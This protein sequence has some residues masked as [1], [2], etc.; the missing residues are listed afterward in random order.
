[1]Q[2][3]HPHPFL[4]PPG[5]DLDTPKTFRQLNTWEYWTV[6]FD[7]TS[8]KRYIYR[9]DTGRTFVV[10]AETRAFHL[11]TRAIFL[12]GTQLLRPTRHPVSTMAA[13]TF[14]SA[15]GSRAGARKTECSTVRLPLPLSC[16]S[17]AISCSV[18]HLL[19]V[20]SAGIDDFKLWTRAI[21]AAEV[22]QHY[23]NGLQ[24]CFP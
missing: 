12:F 3:Q 6:T 20:F 14:T 18:A 16:P 13:A 19:L 11:F 7:Y 8:R 24:V 15:R 17:F 2:Q 5:N 1:M 9:D 21:S 4:L 10:R 22:N 23:L